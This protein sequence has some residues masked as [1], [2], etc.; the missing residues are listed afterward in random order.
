MV[1]QVLGIVGIVTAFGYAGLSALNTPIVYQSYSEQTC[2]RVDDPAKKY[3]CEN[4]PPKYETVWV[5]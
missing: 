4:L 2:E 1:W 5:K 3:N